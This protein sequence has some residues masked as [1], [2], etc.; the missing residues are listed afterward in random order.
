MQLDPAPYDAAGGYL[1]RKVSST[2]PS[3]GP[4]HSMS[5]HQSVLCTGPGASICPAWGQG[6]DWEEMKRFLGDCSLPGP[7]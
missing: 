6:Q 3:L 5:V 7:E 1:H 2:F 4:S